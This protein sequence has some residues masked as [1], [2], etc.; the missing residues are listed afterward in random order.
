M[1]IPGIQQIESVN[2]LRK[3]GWWHHVDRLIGAGT[4]GYPRTTQRRLRILNMFCY[5]IALSTLSYAVQH[6]F[7][8]METYGPVIA[9]NLT[10]VV[11]VLLVP[12]AHRIHETAGGLLITVVE[13]AALFAFMAILGR[14]S[15]VH[16]QYFVGA[17]A[18]FVIFGLGRLRLIVVV[19]AVGLVLN[20]VSWFMFPRQDA[21][22]AAE[23]SVLDSLYVTAAVT[24]CGLIAATVFYAFRLAER[25]QEETDSLL[26]N[27]LPESVVERLKLA[28][29]QNIADGFDEATVL[30]ADLVGFTPL[31]KKLGPRQTVRMLNQVISE[32]DEKADEFGVEKI[33]TIGDAYMAV[34][35]VP[36]VS[37]DHAV[38]MAR[39]AL[40]LKDTVHAFSD[41]QGIKL[42]VRVGMASGPVMAGVIGR[43]KFT[44]DI[45]GD[46]VNLAARM[47]S[48]GEPGKI[49]VPA[50]LKEIL[51]GNFEFEP[52]GVK[53]IKGI[54]PLETWYLL[55]A[56]G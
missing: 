24:T 28:P 39:M 54:G 5:L 14:P 22:I 53:E 12:L 31:S 44:Y 23:Q 55:G 50:E 41:E 26:R 1:R 43:R 20:I 36:V 27:I 37:G 48:H 56:K 35:G 30:F 4:Q 46:T 11:L 6:M 7:L 16:M 9:I 42:D 15:G 38:Q 33:K 18:P 52:T 17:A 32:L 51:D 45:W 21:I 3:L 49:Q 47:E 8:D 34:T 13:Y 25:A 19:V 2:R 40:A 29:E 10:I